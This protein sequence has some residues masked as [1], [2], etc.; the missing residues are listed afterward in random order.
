MSIMKWFLF[1]VVC[2]KAIIMETVGDTLVNRFSYLLL[3]EKQRLLE[4]VFFKKEK[5]PF[6]EHLLCA[7]H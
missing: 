5:L 4:V 7:R 1:R 2:S 6:I 3:P